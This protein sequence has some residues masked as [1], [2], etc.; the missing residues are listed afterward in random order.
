M[1]E[2]LDRIEK[3]VDQITMVLGGNEELGQKG[4]LEDYRE[5]KGHVFQTKADVSKLKWLVSGISTLIG[6]AWAAL[7]TWYN[8]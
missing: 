7:V 8:S 1:S 3:K 5:I 2:Q 4:L 6:G